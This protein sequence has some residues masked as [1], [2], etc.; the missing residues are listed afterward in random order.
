MHNLRL[1]TSLQINLFCV[2]NRVC[3][4][5]MSTVTP[6]DFVEK[7][8]GATGVLCFGSDGVGLGDLRKKI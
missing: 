3:V 8:V 4:Y 5:L 2:H 1:Q 7:A 6:L